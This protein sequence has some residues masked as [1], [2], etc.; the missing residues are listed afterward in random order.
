[1][2]SRL[3]EL[4]VSAVEM[5]VPRFDDKTGRFLTQ[6]DG[7]LAPGATPEEVGWCPINQDVL[8]A[9]ATVYH[10]PHN[11]YFGNPRIL[12]LASQAGDAI[13]DFQY[14][15]GQVEFIKADGSKWGPTY[16]GWT[17][18]A[19]LEAYALLQSELDEERRQRWVE[20]LTLAHDGQARELQ[21][22]AVHNIPA[23]KAMSCYRAGQLL[24]RPDW[25]EVGS[26]MIAKVVAEQDPGG[27]WPEHG[28]PSTLYNLVYVHAL[29]LYH[30]F[31]HD[32]SVLPALQAATEFHDTFTYPDG[33]VVET[34]DGRV[35]YHAGI[36]LFGWSA[37]SLFPKGQRHV[38]RLL[39][40]LSPERDLV[41]CQG[42]LLPTAYHHVVD[43]GNEDGSEQPDGLTS[44]RDQAL[45][46]KQGPWFACLSAFTGPAANS[47][48]GQDR[49][50]FLSLW[51]R[52]CGLIMGGGNSKEQPEWSSFVADGRYLPDRARVVDDGCGVAFAY[53]GV[54]CLLELEWE[55]DGVAIVG[56]AE[57]GSAVQQLVL[58]LNRGET[59]RTETGLELRL[60]EAPVVLDTRQLGAWLATEKWRIE[61]PH[62]ARLQ[63]PS[64]PFNPYAADGAAPAGAEMGVLSAHIDG[65]SIRWRITVE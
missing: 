38:R 42:G 12:E 44:Y 33:A 16:M 39:T 19:W 1:M 49:Q 62:G 52:D 5:A 59:L 27:Y 41:S 3:L 28:G 9:L 26:S 30:R 65:N 21:T 10:E 35:K 17:N 13:R 46:Q 60:G 24:G 31:S 36:S 64:V 11:P 56:Q 15:D 57:K 40:V 2:K 43:D 58:N 50:N 63:W 51:H 14:P 4:L 20:G 32:E 29:G 34:I 7:P 25:Q 6:P 8:Y 54:Y 22:A 61:L 48:W 55:A 23:W 53:G 47:R 37:F 18:Y 45:V